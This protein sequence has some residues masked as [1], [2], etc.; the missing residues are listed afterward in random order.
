ME[1]NNKDYRKS[2]LLQHIETI[3]SMESQL[4]AA[5]M[6]AFVAL[7]EQDQTIDSWEK[8]H[9]EGQNET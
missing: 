2:K 6:A 8:E 9:G 1:K 7:A 4:K 3:L 5:S